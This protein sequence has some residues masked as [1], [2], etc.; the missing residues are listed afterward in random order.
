MANE[1]SCPSKLV[2]NARIALIGDCA[3]DSDIG[4]QKPF[5]GSAG[6]ILSK[7]MNG[8]QLRMDE[9]TLNY[10]IKEACRN[11]DVSHLY[12]D[13]R[14]LEPTPR[15]LQYREQLKKELSGYS[16][17]QPN[18]AVAVGEEALRSLTGL[19][20]IQKYR[21]SILPSNLVPG[22]KVIPLLRPS[23][24]L[25][26]QW[27]YFWI[28]MQD[29]QRV[30]RESVSKVIKPLAWTSHINPQAKDVIAFF[31]SIGSDAL[32][33]IDIET[34]GGYIACFSVASGSTALCVPLQNTCGTNYFVGDEARIWRALQELMNRNPNLIGQNLT[35]DLD[36]LMDRGLEPSGIFMDTM[37]AHAIL[38]PEFPKGLDF[39]ASIYT[40]MPYYKDEGKTWNS[41]VPDKQLWEYNNKDTITTLWAAQEIEKELKQRNLASLYHDY[42]NVELGLALEMQRLR[43]PIS[44]DNRLEL[45]NCIDE[46]LKE[47]RGRWPQDSK[48][49]CNSPKQVTEYLYTTLGL[50]GKYK[51]GS[52]QQSLRADEDAIMELR[53]EYPDVKELKW[54]LEER[55]LRK[56]KSSYIDVPRD[57]DGRLP[58]AWYVCGTE[59]GRWSSGKSNRGRGTNLQTIPKPLRHMVV[60]PD[61]YIFVQPDLSQAEARMVAYLA[62]CEKLIGLFND[63]SKN[64]HMENG[65]SIFGAYP[66]KDSPDYVLAKACV[67]A[68]NYRMQAKT[69]SVQA[70]ITL[71]KASEVLEGYH[72]TYPEIRQWH[73][74]I[75]DE[76]FRTGVLR[77]PFGRERLFYQ[78]RAEIMLTGKMSNDAWRESLAYKPQATIPDIVNKAMIQLWEKFPEARFFH[79]GHD[80]FLTAV[81]VEMLHEVATAIK[82]F[83][84]MPLAVE[85]IDGITRTLTIPAETACGYSW[86]AMKGWEG[87]ETLTKEEWESWA[88]KKYNFNAIKDDLLHTK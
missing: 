9:C 56:L 74:H 44:E 84:T 25:Q 10:V 53:A 82:V 79:Q 72:A 83:C 20:G 54:L 77:T 15:L 85:G 2:R 36:Y 75:R 70:G 40:S 66:V 65:K 5:T 18:V 46:A 63:T 1:P 49:N 76:V 42:V 4:E 22:L 23:F 64:I 58:G 16:T 69:F 28:G 59:T 39:L 35:F 31:N 51:F 38:H 7:M 8:A 78:A 19:Q 81:P 6:R 88:A 47:V 60:P 3:S 17:Y 87:E 11:G 52:G 33:C 34:R 68:S 24:I 50:K 55:H 62:G 26:G 73:Q 30:R 14:Q 48:L 37:V 12:K 21:G 41:K 71:R 13:A 61:G 57:A 43:L 80:A 86:L 29:F 32:W 45:S 27:K 67:H